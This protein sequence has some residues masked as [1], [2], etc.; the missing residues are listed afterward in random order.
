MNAD[1]NT[2]SRNILLA[3]VLIAVA[4]IYR[5]VPHPPNVAP[6]TAIALFGGAYINR[7]WLI[8]LVPFA[9]LYMSDFVLNNTALRSYYPDIEGTVFWSQYMTGTF[10]AFGLIICLGLV[11]L[12]KVSALRVVNISLV[13]S[14]L[15]FLVTNF[16]AWLGSPIYPQSFSGLLTSYGAG[17]PFFRP[18]I[19]GD[20]LFT[21]VLFG[22]MELIK[23]SQFS[24][25]VNNSVLDR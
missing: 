2:K 22:A 15:F 17:I 20:L 3:I 7:K 1:T 12:K 6:I 25:S 9:A 5:L 23:K 4:A 14:A 13:S 21:G 24:M 10:L 19:L 18:T 11:F 8:F 16:F